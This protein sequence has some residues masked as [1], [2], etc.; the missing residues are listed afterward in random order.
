M[1]NN[2]QEKTGTI[3]AFALTANEFRILL[4]SV[5]VD[6]LA[7]Y[8]QDLEQYG[9]EILPANPGLGRCMLILIDW[10]AAER[11]VTLNWPLATDIPLHDLRAMIST[12]GEVRF[13][14]C[15]SSVDARRTL[16]AIVGAKITPDD[17][18]RIP[19]TYA[20]AGTLQASDFIRAFELLIVACQIAASADD[21]YVLII[22]DQRAY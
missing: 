20:L 3:R 12:S 9:D 15:M 13:V 19:A 8:W 7:S 16:Q 11:R 1:T 18:A 17:L 2:N 5:H 10:L 4:A 6:N 21:R 14:A 22:H